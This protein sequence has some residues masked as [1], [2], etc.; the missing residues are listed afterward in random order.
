MCGIVGGWGKNEWPIA[1]MLEGIA[2]RG[3]DHQ[4]TFVEA[5]IFLGH[6]RLSIQDLSESGNQPMMSD[7]GRH[8][9]IFNGEI[10]NHFD[11]RKELPPHSYRST[12]DTETI[13][14]AYQQWGIDCLIK[15]NGIFAF[16]LFDRQEQSLLLAR[17]R[18]GVKPLYFSAS[19]S[20]VVFSSEIKALLPALGD[21]ALDVRAMANYLTF[22]WSPGSD[23]PFQNVKKLD[24]GTSILFHFEKNHLKTSSRK[25]YQTPFT[26]SYSTA[27]EKE[28]IDTCEQK[29]LKAVNRQLLS[30]VPVGFFLSGGLDSSLIVAMAK[31]LHPNQ[32]W[33]CFTIDAGSEITDEGFVNDLSYAKKVANH[34]KVELHIVKADIDILRDFDKMIWH[35]DEPQADAAPLNV[36]NICKQARAMGFKVLIGGTAGDDVFSGYRRHQALQFEK[37]LKLIPR[38]VSLGFLKLPLNRKNPL[39]RR[40]SKVLSESAEPTEQRLANYYRW[41]PKETVE[42]LFREPYHSIVKQHNPTSYLLDRLSDIPNETS[43]LNKMLYWEMRSFLVDHNLN[44]TDKMAMAHGVEVRVPFLDNELVEFACTIPPSL[45][46]KGKETKYILKKVAER[47]LPHEVIYR[48]KTGFGAPVRRWIT[49]E[50]ST[51]IADR[52]SEKR[53]NAIGIFDYQKVQQLIQDNQSGKVDASYSIWCLLAIESWVRQFADIKSN[54]IL[55]TAYPKS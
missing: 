40:A 38:W 46:M 36:S 6:T 39:F 2:H 50:K 1:E 4:A 54:K 17:D 13:L 45:K 9:I 5:K 26:G 30:D 35:L 8:V 24:P 11:L 55:E 29:L 48:P 18:F 44:Y 41:L 31:K 42:K 52:L 43:W 19:E 10:Y 12:S 53:I 32:Q 47:Y 34:L 21:K 25:F 15:L 37:Y 28:L 27:R 33:N 16:A 7:D 20:E 14:V 22:L 23:T 49:E 51:T 3:P